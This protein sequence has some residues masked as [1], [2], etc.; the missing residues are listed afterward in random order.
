M[1]EGHYTDLGMK[2][3]NFMRFG[4]LVKLPKTEAIWR[5][6]V[7]FDADERPRHARHRHRP[8]RAPH[9]RGARHVGL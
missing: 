1:Y 5:L 2:M 3:M 7:R 8:P 4:S 9:P 6:T